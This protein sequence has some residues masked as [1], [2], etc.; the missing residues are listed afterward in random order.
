[1]PDSS[2][3]ETT[4][5]P[6]PPPVREAVAGMMHTRHIPG[7]AL[8]VTTTESLAYVGA[9]GQAVLEPR[10]PATP[11][12]AWLWF[13][14]SKL[15]T[16]TAAMRLAHQ[17][18][19]D[20]D[21]PFRDYLP[22]AHEVRTSATVRQLLNHTSGIG[23]PLPI[24]WVHPADAPDR[25]A[26]L[27]ARL[28]RTISRP[29]RAPGGPAAYSNV[30]YLVLGQVLAAA[31]GRPFRDLVHQSVLGPAG[32]T[33]TGYRYA[34]GAPAA[35]GYVRAPRVVDPLLR[36][37]LPAGVLGARHGRQV[38]LRQFLVDGA[39]YGGLVGPITDAARFARLHLRDG[40]L[41]GQRVL[42]AESAQEMR[43]VRWPGKRFDHGLG[44][45]RKPVSDPGRPE[46]VEHYG[47]GAGFWNAMRLYP[48]AGL[49]MVVMANTTQPYD[50][51]T[52]FEAVRHHAAEQRRH[53]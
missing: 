7:L 42:A 20:L 46:F 22:D 45:F 3:P 39:A 32:M 27:Y 18:E 31:S 13:S 19:L 43:Q 23:N 52:L 47:A 14:M 48:S 8:A 30:G 37:L 29:R 16:A 49:G 4:T 17:G 44:W 41:D 21:A 51:D 53:D 34:P 25:D 26:D 28:H 33:A 5:L 10:Q 38:S 50:I 11:D 1:M 2:C 12:M 40:E 36:A 9:F 35:A 24:R 15:V 6:V